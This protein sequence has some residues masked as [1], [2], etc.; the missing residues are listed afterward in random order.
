LPLSAD[1]EQIISRRHAPSSESVAARAAAHGSRAAGPVVGTGRYRTH[2]GVGPGAWEGCGGSYGWAVSPG[3]GTLQ[4]FAAAV[5]AFGRSDELSVGWSADARRSARRSL[6][7]HGLCLLGEVHGVAEN[8]LIIE[9]LVA[10]L[11]VEVVAL[12]WPR[13]LELA[14][15]DVARLGADPPAI[16]RHFRERSHDELAMAA[17]WFG[18]GRVTAGH[19]AAL[20]RIPSEVVAVDE[21]VSAPAPDARDAA[22]AGNIEQLL[23]SGPDGVLFVAGN[24]HTR[25]SRHEHYEPAGAHL[26]R[27]RPEL[28]GLDIHYVRGRFWNG[29]H[30]TFPSSKPPTRPHLILEQATEATVLAAGNV[31][32]PARSG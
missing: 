28:C 17:A 1:Q 4:E 30:R 21:P 25:L 18:D 15:D 16:G 24:L 9:H 10:E 8:P 7:R 12:E 5:D 32:H 22:M 6:C 29:G 11:G 31:R 26:A 20:R 14:I 23:R 2:A 19:F 3:V 27:D 13:G